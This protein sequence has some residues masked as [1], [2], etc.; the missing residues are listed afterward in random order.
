MTIDWWTLGIQ[1]VN[2][3][4][5]VWLLG[6]FFWR[7]VAAMIEQ[8]RVAA[9]EAFAQV[10]VQRTQATAALADIERTRAGFAGERDALLAAARKAAELERAAI[11]AKAATEAAALEAEAKAAAARDVEAAN[12]AWIER[13]SRLAV[14]IAGRLVERLQGPTAQ[15]AFMDG[16][17]KAIRELPEAARLGATAPGV[18]LEAISATPIEPADRQRF[19]DEIGAALGQPAGID[20]KSDAALIAGYELTAPHF[21]VGNSWRGDLAGILADLVH[22]S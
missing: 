6:H 14:A 16:L 18:R 19:S 4:I 3:V 8:R 7:P 9:R 22:D 12:R 2:I 1:S 5:L 15:D 17:L 13:A 20:F 21:T 10:E 11:L